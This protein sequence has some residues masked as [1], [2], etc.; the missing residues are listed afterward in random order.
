MGSFLKFYGK[1]YL[2]SMKIKMENKK[3]MDENFSKIIPEC[4]LKTFARINNK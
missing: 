4:V 1:L 3:A 2:F